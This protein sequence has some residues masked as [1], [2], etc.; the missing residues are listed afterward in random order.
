MS[1]ANDPLR[2]LFPLTTGLLAG[3][4]TANFG[5]S[6]IENK[7]A[8]GPTELTCVYQLN[9]NNSICLKS[10]GK[11]CTINAECET[12]NCSGNGSTGYTCAPR[13]TQQFT[14]VNNKFNNNNKELFSNYNQNNKFQKDI[15]SISKF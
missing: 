13:L 10:V 1:N 6:C 12:N 4:P 3:P 9:N 2:V 11:N 14:N 15:K 7:C 8:G 5:E